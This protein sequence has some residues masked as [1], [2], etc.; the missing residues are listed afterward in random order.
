MGDDGFGGRELS[1]DD[2]LGETGGAMPELELDRH[3]SGQSAADPQDLMFGSTGGR[4]L[5]DPFEGMAGAPALELD[6]DAVRTSQPSPAPPSLPPPPEPASPV[7]PRRP[8]ATAPVRTSAP[9]ERP[10]ASPAPAP[11]RAPASPRSSGAPP[12]AITL[13]DYGEPPS[14]IVGT[15]P[16]AVHVGLRQRALRADLARLRRLRD[17]AEED[18]DE[19]MVGLGR[20]LH[21]QRDDERLQVLS[22]PMGAADE[23]GEVASEHSTEWKKVREAASAQREAIEERVARAEEEAAPVRARETELGAEVSR[24]EAALQR[25]KAKLARTNIELRNLA[26][27]ESPDPG[28]RASLEAEREVHAAE[29]ERARA[30]VDELTPELTEV[31]R[32]LASHTHRVTALEKE[33]REVDRSRGRSE[34]ALSTSAKAAEGRYH[35]AVKVVAKQALERGLAAAVAPGPAKLATNR[36]DALRAREEEIELHEIALTLHDRSSLHKGLA[37]L[38]VLSAIVLA[39]LIFVVVR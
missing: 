3:G 12:R 34:E 27:A 29:V 25:A 36:A 35:E 33:A 28:R 30:Q 32:Q 11:D 14:G 17:G 22:G 24:R 4:D 13:A 6:L 10:R 5:A 15:V 38:G 23:A 21:A 39:M 8:S 26:G 9:P 19:A 18:L 20:A 31:R 2:A 1:L 7:P 16:Y 37:I